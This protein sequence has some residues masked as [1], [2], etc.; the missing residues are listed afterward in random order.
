MIPIRG[1]THVGDRSICKKKLAVCA[2]NSATG[3]SVVFPSSTEE[4]ESS[5][6]RTWDLR[7]SAEDMGHLQS[8]LVSLH[9]I[10]GPVPPNHRTPLHSL[11]L[12]LGKVHTTIGC[13]SFT[14]EWLLFSEVGRK[15]RHV[16]YNWLKIFQQNILLLENASLLTAKCMTETCRF[17]IFYLEQKPLPQH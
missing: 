15:T 1:R 2:T 13:I 10:W 16:H 7:K 9:R 17:L 4:S 14:A 3:V 8:D 11:Q 5:A 6:P 12:T